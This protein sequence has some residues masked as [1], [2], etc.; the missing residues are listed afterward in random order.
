LPTWCRNVAFGSS[1]TFERL[2]RHVRS[3]P[4]SVR[5]AAIRVLRLWA[6]FDQSALQQFSEAANLPFRCRVGSAFLRGRPE[7]VVGALRAAGS[8][9]EIRPLVAAGHDRSESIVP[10]H[11]GYDENQRVVRC[12]QCVLQVLDGLDDE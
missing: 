11:D 7:L 5:V 12:A 10:V 6:S 2:P 3:S 1:A 8:V 4:H 9:V